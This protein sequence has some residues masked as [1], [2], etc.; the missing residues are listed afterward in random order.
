MDYQLTITPTHEPV[1]LEQAKRHL[2]L[3]GTGT[4]HDTEIRALLAAARQWCEEYAGRSFLW[5]TLAGKLDN[6]S[7][8]II[9]LPRPPLLSV[10]SITYYD[11]GGTLQ[12]VTST[13]YA[14]D[15]TSEPGKVVLGYDKTWPSVRGHHHD[16]TITFAAGHAVTWTRSGTDLVVNGHLCRVGELVQVYNVGGALPAGLAVATNYYVK[17]VSGHTISLSL[18]EDGAAIALADAGT[19]THYLDALPQHYHSAILLRLTDLWAHRGDENTPPSRALR[20][21]LGIGRMVPA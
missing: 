18:T 12:T 15:V 10:S 2:R 11:S 19:G 7:K 8:S 5:Q 3:D 4:E 20:E 13:D 21:L 9:L 1:S 6:L 16:V 17:T 14:A